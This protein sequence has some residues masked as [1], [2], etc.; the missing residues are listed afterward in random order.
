[1]LQPPPPTHLIP[2]NGK[3]ASYTFTL[4]PTQPYLT[5]PPHSSCL[6]NSHWLH[7]KNCTPFLIIQAHGAHCLK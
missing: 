2:G 6:I 3:T 1:M 5:T 7:Q 4:L